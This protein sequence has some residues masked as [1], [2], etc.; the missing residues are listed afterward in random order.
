MA[1]IIVLPLDMF[2]LGQGLNSSEY[3][4]RLSFR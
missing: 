1:C 2:G 3:V 4:F